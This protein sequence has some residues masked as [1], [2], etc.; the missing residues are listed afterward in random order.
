MDTDSRL[1]PSGMTNVRYGDAVWAAVESDGKQTTSA[2]KAALGI[3]YNEAARFTER[4]VADGILSE[5]DKVGRRTLLKNFC[6]CCE[7]CAA[8]L[9]EDDDYVVDEGGSAICKP[10]VEIVGPCYAARVGGLDASVE[11]ASPNTNSPSGD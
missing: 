4:M 3:S 5:P 11:A 10:A 9:F 8:P 1:G 2:V 7:A 6:G